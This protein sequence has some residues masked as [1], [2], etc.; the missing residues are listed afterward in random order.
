VE[1][2]AVLTL[3]STISLQLVQKLAKGEGK[4]EERNYYYWSL[5]ARRDFALKAVMQSCKV[6]SALFLN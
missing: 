1:K 4:D 2:I 5:P 3:A 6:T